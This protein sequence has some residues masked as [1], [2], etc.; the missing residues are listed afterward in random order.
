MSNE[1]QYLKPFSAIVVADTVPND[2]DWNIFRNERLI[3]VAGAIPTQVLAELN[4]HRCLSK[5]AES[6]RAVPAAEYLSRI[7]SDG[8]YVPPPLRRSKSMQG[9]AGLLPAEEADAWY[10][11]RVKAFDDAVGHHK[12]EMESGV[13]KSIPNRLLAPFSFTRLVITGTYAGWMS[14][15]D[16][17]VSVDADVGFQAFISRCYRAILGSTPRVSRIHCPFVEGP[18]NANDQDALNIFDLSVSC[19]A[20]ISYGGIRRK[21]P[22]ES[23]R[24]VDRLMT[25]QHWGPFEHQALS[26]DAEVLVD[27]LGERARIVQEQDFSGNFHSSNWVQYR[28]LVEYM[29]SDRPTDS[30]EFH[31]SKKDWLDCD[32]IVTHE[33]KKIKLVVAGSR[34]VEAV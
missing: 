30:G 15:F 25:D 17:R 21:T 10:R 19:C 4:T 34:I 9:V 16:K 13:H 5:S 12:K 27:I 3:T 2:N 24:M 31:E 8:P 14:V 7:V 18:G 33:G 20:S 23:K 11:S 26:K 6:T 1:I 22:E 29:S 32:A 28:K